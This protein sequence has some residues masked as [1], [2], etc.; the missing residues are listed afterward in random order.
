MVKIVML[1][2]FREYKE[3]EVREV[4]NNEAFGL[5]EAGIAKDFD[6]D[7]NPPVKPEK[8]SVKRKPIKRTRKVSRKVKRVKQVKGKQTKDMTAGRRRSY[9][10]K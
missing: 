7:V 1:K 2:D 9:K 3:G 4:H 8:R 5:K 6:W 10:T